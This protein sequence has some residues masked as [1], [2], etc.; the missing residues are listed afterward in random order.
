M[1]LLFA[2][3]F[4]VS[5]L[6]LP[7][8]FLFLLLP[9]VILSPSLLLFPF[10]SLFYK[11]NKYIKAIFSTRALSPPSLPPSLPPSFF[12]PSSS[13]SHRKGGPAF[14]RMHHLPTLP[15]CLVLVIGSGGGAARCC[16]CC[17]RCSY[18]WRFGW[19]WGEGR[20]EVSE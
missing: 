4:T 7:L 19:R 8:L 17:C 2:W 6:L 13:V 10:L 14:P 16:C 5:L 9:L 20:K 18:G 11:T 15:V 12:P 3:F 1:C